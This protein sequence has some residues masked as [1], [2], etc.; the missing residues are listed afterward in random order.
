VHLRSEV[1]V[2][3]RQTLLGVHVGVSIELEDVYTL[4]TDTVDPGVFI[5]VLISGPRLSEGR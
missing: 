5:V 3:T 4:T 2:D 1:D